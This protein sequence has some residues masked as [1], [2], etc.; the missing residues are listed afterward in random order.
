MQ[1]NNFNPDISG[2]LSGAIRRVLEENW[3]DELLV[4]AGLRI[5]PRGQRLDQPIASD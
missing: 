1:T 3:T 5:V 2:A 4:Q